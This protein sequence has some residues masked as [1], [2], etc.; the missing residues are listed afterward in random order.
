MPLDRAQGGGGPRR[1]ASEM[2]VLQAHHRFL[3]DESQAPQTYEA[4]IAR[5]YA[6]GLYKEVRRP[7]DEFAVA[8]LKHYRTR[9][10]ALRWRT[11]EEVLDGIGE[12]TCGNQ[13]C[14]W[15]TR[16]GP[17]LGT[18]EV[19]FA[20]TEPSA[21]GASLAKQALVKVGRCADQLVLCGACAAKLQEASR[22]ART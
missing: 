19:P 13:R 12:H 16:A 21:S 20:Y 4:E 14:A 3:H 22:T 9:G 15:Y 5:K 1:G 11:E 8:N 2:D 7:T 18:Y 17:K 10:I 6:D